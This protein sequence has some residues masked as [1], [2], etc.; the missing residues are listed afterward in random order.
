MGV[1]FERIDGDDRIFNGNELESNEDRNGGARFSFCNS[2]KWDLPLIMVELNSVEDWID[3]WS[4]LFDIIVDDDR[5]SSSAISHKLTFA[6]V[7][8]N[9]WRPNFKKK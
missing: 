8:H 2:F 9:F 3:C 4:E 1:V 5:S 7:E 6:N